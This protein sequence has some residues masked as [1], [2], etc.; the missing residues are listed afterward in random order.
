[1][2]LWSLVGLSLI[3]IVWGFAKPRRIPSPEMRSK[4]VENLANADRRLSIL[5]PA[6]NDAKVLGR[7]LDSLIR[8]MEGFP[9]PTELIVIA[10]GGD[11]TY[12]VALHWRASQ[13]FEPVI[14][15][16]QSPRGKNAALN[17]GIRRATGDIYV[18]VDADTEVLPNWLAELISPIVFG[19]AE[20]TTALFH[21]FR[22]TPVSH[23]FILEQFTAQKIVGD[24]ALFGGG[25]IAVA[26]E[27]LDKI[28]G[29]PEG[30]LVGVDWD[31]TQRLR[32][33]GC[34]TGF[35]DSA[36]VI[37]EISESWPQFWRGEVRWRRAWWV[38]QSRGTGGRGMAVYALSVSL[39]LMASAIA[40]L[41]L[42]FFPDKVSTTTVIAILAVMVWGLG[43]YTVR[44]VQY[45]AANRSLPRLSE[46]G[47]YFASVYVSSLALI[48]G[49]STVG[50]LTPHFKGARPEGNAS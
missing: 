3:K 47:A 13:K 41:L 7:C 28:G 10:G 12:E 4:D 16:E 19:S 44:L 29:L 38:L 33:A 24:G 32:K 50:K 9:L 35:V 37:T 1:M 6:W 49:V 39:A 25:T 43:P 22:R 48:V 11:G 40:A 46:I 34:R 45:A 20:A 15:V 30:V 14:I 21:P 31:L 18:F 17:D 2:L 36:Q 26:R 42:V 27:A 23:I 5:V 8:E